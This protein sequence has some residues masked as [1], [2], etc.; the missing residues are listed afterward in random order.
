MP[1]APWGD[2]YHSIPGWRC[3]RAADPQGVPLHPKSRHQKGEPEKN[4][5][6]PKGGEIGESKVVSTHLW[7]TPLNVY[8]RERDSFHSELGGLPGVCS[9]GVL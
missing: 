4:V 6:M 7:N 5:K 1:W 8:Q 9:T 3:R 2:M